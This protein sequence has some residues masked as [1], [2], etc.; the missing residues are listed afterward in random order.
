MTTAP[1]SGDD[2]ST[3]ALAA[4]EEQ[5][6]MRRLVQ[7]VL[8]RRCGNVRASAQVLGMSP[9]TLHRRINALGLREWLTAEYERGARQPP[10][11]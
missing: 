7:W 2:A 5:D 1:D 11:P 6:A 10:R 8:V 4:E 9:S 3:V